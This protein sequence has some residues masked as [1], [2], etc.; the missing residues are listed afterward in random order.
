MAKV[1]TLDTRESN[2]SFI[3]YLMDTSATLGY[4]VQLKSLYFGDIGFENIIV[5]RKEINDF[6][7]SICDNRIHD[8]IAK[9]RA[10]TDYVSIIAIS[11]TYGNL[12][13]NNMD[14]IPSINGTF[15]Q[16]TAWGIP[17]IHCRDDNDLVDK[18]LELF[19]YA[20]PVDTP[21]KHVEK[22]TQISLFTALPNIG[23]KNA[24]KIQKEYHDMV[25]LCDASKKEL[26]SLLGPVKGET[27]FNAL[28][29]I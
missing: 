11:G 5:E 29:N 7:S 19:K 3:A 25:T 28:R 17:I 23:K 27:V 6:C 18:V 9:M 21:I 14:K 2:E 4:T 13:K 16:I 12:W 22:D 8:Q 10:N 20:K 1:I 26:Q 15:K 24:K